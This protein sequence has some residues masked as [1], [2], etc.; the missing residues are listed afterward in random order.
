MKVPPYIYFIICVVISVFITLIQ[1]WT[2][3]KPDS[4]YLMSLGGKYYFHKDFYDLVIECVPPYV[5]EYKYDSCFIVARQHPKG[6]DN[7][8]NMFP[9]P[10]ISYPYGTNVPYYWIINKSDSTI[11]GPFDY[12][13]FMITC[14]SLSVSLRL[15]NDKTL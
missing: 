14:D 2:S 11:F 13:Q 12:Q 15:N 1:I 3:A 5:D 4:Y 9:R 10:E 8:K 7:K 6:P